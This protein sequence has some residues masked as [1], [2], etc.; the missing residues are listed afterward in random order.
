LASGPGR[1]GHRRE[2]C[3]RESLAIQV[4]ATGFGEAVV[5]MQ[6]QLWW[7]GV[8]LR[9]DAFESRPVVLGAVH[10]EGEDVGLAL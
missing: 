2:H 5:W 8:D 10:L 9:V 7:E 6:W 4:D 3:E 1:Q